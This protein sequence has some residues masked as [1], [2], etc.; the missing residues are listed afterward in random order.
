MHPVWDL[1]P[2]FFTVPLID[3]PIRYYGLFF[4][5]AFLLGFLLYRW[6][7]VR[8]GGSEEDAVS[9][10]IPG[11]L[12]TVIGARLGHVLFYNMGHFLS[13]PAWIF[14]IWDG[15]LASHGAAAG[16]ALALLYQSHR[17][18]L[19]FL[20]LSDRFSFSAALGAALIRLGNF[21][22]SEIVGKVAPD[23]SPFGVRF[24]L[25]DGPFAPPRYP[26]QLL[27]SLMGFLILG[28]LLLADRRMGRNARPLGALSGLF[29]ILY[30]LGR[31][32]VEFL[33]ERQGSFDNLAL[34]RGQQ[35]SLL[36]LA[37]GICLFVWALWRRAPGNP[38]P[39]GPADR[40]K[41]PAT[42]PKGGGRGRKGKRGKGR[43]GS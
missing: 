27:E 26:T 24:P 9:F 7:T 31:F 5:A 19:P 22:N 39:G 43:K 29:L 42:N 37:L 30:F 32:L 8:S 21:C 1:D 36:P 40:A 33:K 6:Q 12:G 4:A 3:R 17:K 2:V 16:L 38:A 35:L 14:R 20:C 13:D 23:G 10:I 41:P 15:G 34:S 28:A 25:Y 18:K 11:F